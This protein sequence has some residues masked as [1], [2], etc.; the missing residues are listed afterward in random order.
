[1]PVFTIIN[2]CGVVVGSPFF[3]P[4]FCKGKE[5]RLEIS[6]YLGRT[7]PLYCDAIRL[8]ISIKNQGGDHKKASIKKIL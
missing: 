3:F 8:I 5:R 7:G 1:M 2:S 6:V 4:F